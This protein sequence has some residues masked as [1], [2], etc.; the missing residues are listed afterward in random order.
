MKPHSPFVRTTLTLLSVA[1]LAALA[2]C[3]LTRQSAVKQVFLLAP[4]LPAPVAKTQP[5]SLRV[6]AVAIAAP[7]R[8]RAFVYRSGEL[9][10]EPDY[11]SE[12]LVPPSVMLS[13]QTARALDHARAFATVA[14]PGAGTSTDWVLEGFVSELYADA[15]EAQ[16]AA[17]EVTVSYFLTRGTYQALPVWTKEYHRRVPL[18]SVTANGYAE[19]LNSAFAEIYAGLASDLASAELPK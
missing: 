13:E 18:K 17:A 14:L 5:A 2:A 7:F 8:G 16:G 12:F 3:A 15:R 6:G 4:A 1:A 9:R 19:A 10:Y 11:Y